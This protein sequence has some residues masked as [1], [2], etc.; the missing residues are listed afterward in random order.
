MKMAVVIH[1]VEAASTSETSVNYY[2]PTRHNDP[3]GCYLHNRCRENLKF[4][5]FIPQ[6]LLNLQHLSNEVGFLL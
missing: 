4:H 6:L 5:N 3:Q 1:D 2:Q